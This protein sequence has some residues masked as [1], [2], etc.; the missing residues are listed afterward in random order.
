MR[1]EL[2]G[3]GRFCVITPKS[4]CT[5]RKTKQFFVKSEALTGEL[6]P[7][8]IQPETQDIMKIIFEFLKPYRKKLILVAAL[9]AIATFTSLLLPYVMSL[10]V[11]EGIT[12]K[13]ASIIFI[14]AAIM[15]ALAL[16][17]L[18]TSILSNKINSSVATSFT[19]KL[20]TANFKKVNSLSETQYSKIGSSGLLTRSTDDIFNLEGAASELVYTLVTVPI[21]LIGGTIL[22]FA[23]DP[24]L[25]LIFLVSVPPVLVFIVFLVKPLGNL[26]DKADKYIDMQNR[27]IRERLSGLRVIRAFN[28]EEKEHK[29]A[30]HAT[31][32][33]AKYIIK[34]NVRSGYIEPV[35]MLLLNFATVLILWFGARR[36]EIGKLAE[37]GDVIAVIQYVALIAN[38]VLMLSWTIAWLPKLKVSAKRISEIFDMEIC[39]VG[40]DDSFISPFDSSE[41]AMIEL[42]GVNFTYP[43]AS[44]PTLYDVS[45]KIEKGESVSIIGGTGSGKSTLIKLLLAFYTPENG[46]I[47]IN[48]LPYSELQKNE[49]RSAFSTALQRAMIF[50]GSFRD[51]I[52]MGKR[53]A[54]DEEIM[55]AAESAELS[56][57]INSHGE[58]LSYILVG[59]GQN[60]SGGQKQRTNMARAL[61]KEASVYIFDDSFSALDYLTERKIQKKLKDRLRGK[62]KITVTQRVSTALSSDKIFVME[63]GRIV[64]VGTHEELIKTSPVYREIALS[65]LGSAA[66]GGEIDG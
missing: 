56:E 53:D 3:L 59:L 28:N 32:E 21:M 25:S 62:T 58:G 10:I 12:K 7:Q 23:S 26:W 31:E 19:A 55:S 33:M 24:M 36:A 9:H 54:S 42:R 52:N 15:L 22:S 5:A 27:V 44:I 29:R 38:A 17:S 11:D 35:A 4:R 66:I 63:R 65:Q 20:C 49:I 1:P 34:S 61:L 37:A 6:R 47:Y 51:N 40:A 13:D 64:G 48:S 45:M 18:V 14:S 41:G 50:E 39:D 57:L 16:I 46:E 30:K 2:Y 43:D 8:E 60:I